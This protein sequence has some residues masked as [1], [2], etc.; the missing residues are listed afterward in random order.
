MPDSRV[1]V[2][3]PVRVARHGQGNRGF[4]RR[5]RLPA[6]AKSANVGDNTGGPFV[7]RTF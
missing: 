5:F 1:L 2:D 4:A 3:Q 7:L 6:V